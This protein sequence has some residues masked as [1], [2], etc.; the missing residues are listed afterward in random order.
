MRERTRSDEHQLALVLALKCYPKLDYFPKVDEV[1]ETVVEHVRGA[2]ELAEGTGPHYESVNTAKL[3]PKMVRERQGISYDQERARRSPRRQ[4][5][6]RRWRR[7]IR[8]T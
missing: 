6:W 4:S 2:L 7:T 1:S 8:R 3:H 5:G